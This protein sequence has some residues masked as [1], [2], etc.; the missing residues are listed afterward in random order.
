[1]K[2]YKGV[3]EEGGPLIRA[4]FAADYT[5]PVAEAMGWPEELPSKC[6][7]GKLKGSIRI[8]S[9]V[10][11]PNEKTL[12]QHETQMTATDVGAF[13][14]KVKTDKEGIVKGTELLFQLRTVDPV[15]A[16]AF[17][18]WQRHIGEGVA[19]LKLDCVKQEEMDFNAE[20]QETQEEE[21][22]QQT[23]A[24]DTGAPLASAREAGTSS[25]PGA[26]ARGAAKAGVN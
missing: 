21:E 3:S 11:T 12:K 8:N 18:N 22:T 9:I 13:R 10:L 4:D 23:L 19:A 14:F 6:G 2:Y 24:D 17:Q 25:R 16:A 7:E 15:A 26:R 20:K 5:S 1:M